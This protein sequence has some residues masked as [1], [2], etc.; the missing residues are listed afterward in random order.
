MSP[1]A[2]PHP[3]FLRAFAETRGYLL[4]RPT[5][6]APTPDGRAV[7]FLR[8][9]PRAP[10]QGLY[11][12]DLATGVERELITPDEVLGGA[13]EELSAEEQARRERQR[14]TDRG[15][16]WFALAPDG[17]RVLLALGGRLH[18]VDRR[19]RAVR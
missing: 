2:H 6:L 13:A 17:G 5:R 1:P 10:D 8:S 11:E 18:L 16:T 19:S 12:L 14:I 7:L 15:F 4:G 3:G 9:P